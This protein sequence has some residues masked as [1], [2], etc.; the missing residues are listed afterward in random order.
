MEIP[1][2][3]EVHC[4]K[5]SCGRSVAI[6]LDPVTDQ[7]THVV[8][9][10][11]RVPR[12]EWLVPAEAVQAADRETIELKVSPE[13]L[14]GMDPFIGTRFIRTNAEHF[15][16]R[17]AGYVPGSTYLWPYVTR[18]QQPVYLAEQ[19]EQI[20]PGEV[21]VHRGATVQAADGRA[22]KIDEFVVSESDGRIT[23]LILRRGQLWWKR[24]VVVPVA[25]VREVTG[26][27]VYLKLARQEVAR[28][29]AVP[30][31]RTYHG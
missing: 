8:V 20:P 1:I 30:V 29:P 3:A 26:D 10:A 27:I 23:H 5:K 13:Q 7:V 11:H 22:G 6:I 18:I 15:V 19:E 21:A 12:Q 31:H 16:S 9:R 2:N 17:G 4:A 25:Q 28:L 24:D 14:E